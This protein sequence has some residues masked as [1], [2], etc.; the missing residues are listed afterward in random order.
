MFTACQV[1]HPSQLSETLLLRWIRGSPDAANNSVRVRGALVKVFLRWCQRR[2]Y[3]TLDLDDELATLRKSFPAVHGAKQAK[4]GARRLSRPE[5]DQLFAAC[6]DGTWVGSRDQLAIRLGILGLRVSE[7]LR[8]EWRDVDQ[9]GNLSVR[10]KGHT[11]K[12]VH[13]GPIFRD[14]LVRWRR[15]YE[16]ELGRPIRPSDPVICR[17]QAGHRDA[18][19]LWGVRINQPRTFRVLLA[20]RA[21]LAGIGHLASHTL[22]RSCAQLC[23]E[24]GMGLED[25]R[26]VMR[27]SQATTTQHYLDDMDTGALDR[28]APLLD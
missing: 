13:T 8:L 23:Y 18:P 4:N 20:K 22:R 7:I 3:A 19:I 5:V 1:S 14:Y 11:V 24:A 25:I 15:T 9:T 2:G 21:N 28:A 10:G 6:Q 27:H 17:Q 16:R 26:R 12:P